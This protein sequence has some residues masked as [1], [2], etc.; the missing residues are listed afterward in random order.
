MFCTAPLYSR[1]KL[2]YDNH[3]QLNR[4]KHVL[5]SMTKAFSAHPVAV[6]K[7]PHSLPISLDNILMYKSTFTFQSTKQLYERATSGKALRS[8]YLHGVQ[9]LPVLHP[10]VGGL[11]LSAGLALPDQGVVDG[12]L[13]I[14]GLLNQ[15]RRRC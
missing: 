13:G 8:S 9:R 3:S 10:A 12:P 7:Q 14:L 15:V 4:L 11:G 2:I 1:K 5:L 6:L